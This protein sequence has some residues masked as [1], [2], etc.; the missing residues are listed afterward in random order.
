MAALVAEVQGVFAAD[1]VAVGSSAVRECA[2]LTSAKKFLQARPSGVYTCARAVASAGASTELSKVLVEWSFH[3]Q[4]LSSGL[5][6]VDSNFK[7]DKLKLDKLKM[8]TKSLVAAVLTPWRARETVVDGML[9]VLWYPDAA[10]YIVAIHI[11]PMPQPKCLASTV[12]VYGEARQNARCKHTQW[13]L[14]RLPIEQHVARLVDTRGEPIHEV[15]LSSAGHG[16]NRL[17]L[18]GLITN[19]F[20]GTRWRCMK[21][22]GIVGMA[23]AV[24]FYEVQ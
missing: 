15:V 17:L 8:A 4:R 9:S 3:M 13:I 19:F 12:L 2:E 24:P 11:C 6:S 5:I 10:D 16:G 1:G 20:V 21:V 22:V 14:D 7:H 18:E 23:N